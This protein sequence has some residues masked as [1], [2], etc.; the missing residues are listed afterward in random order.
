MCRKPIRYIFQTML[1]LLCAS[2][3]I[4]GDT[5]YRPL[6]D[7]V[8][9]YA[10]MRSA[11]VVAT[12]VNLEF[13]LDESSAKQL[14]EKLKALPLYVDSYA[15]GNSALQL[16]NSCKNI[17]QI[18]SDK[19]FTFYLRNADLKTVLRSLKESANSESGMCAGD[20]FCVS[21]KTVSVYSATR[22]SLNE[23][24]T[25]DADKKYAQSPLVPTFLVNPYLNFMIKDPDG[26]SVKYEKQ[27]QNCFAELTRYKEICTRSLYQCKNGFAFIKSMQTYGHGN[28]DKILHTAIFR[29]YIAYKEVFLPT[30]LAD[31]GKLSDNK[32]KIQLT[33][34]ES[35]K[36]EN[37]SDNIFKISQKN[38]QH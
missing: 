6:E 5:F 7:S 4:T 24:P 12:G 31:I 25:A 2:C 30:V 14:F 10:E 11:G 3:A 9:K 37:L 20:E 1:L 36:S 22:K 28:A 38:R 18:Y 35:F 27:N 32:F 19:K 8:A 15:D 21:G 17:A 26:V 13:V 34:L 23:W 16:A 33:V 29:N